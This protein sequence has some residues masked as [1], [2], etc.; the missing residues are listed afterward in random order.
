MARERVALER[1]QHPE[2]VHLGHH[3]VGQH[4]VGDSLARPLDAAGA[5]RGLYHAEPSFQ[6]RAEVRAKVRVVFHD[7]HQGPFGVRGLA[8]RHAS[9]HRRC[10]LLP[11]ASG[12]EWLGSG[13]GC[14]TS[15]RRQPAREAERE[16]GAAAHLA[17]DL[18]GAPVQ[19]HDLSHEREA[20]PRALAPPRGLGVALVE[21][22]LNPLQL[23]R[24]DARPGVLDRHHGVVARGPDADRY[25][26]PGR[27]ELDGVGENIVQR[28]LDL[29]RIQEGGDGGLWRVE[30]EVHAGTLCA[31]GERGHART[32]ERDEVYGLPRERDRVRVQTGKRKKVVDEAA[33][34]AAVEGGAVQERPGAA[35]DLE[36]PIAEVVQRADQQRQW[37]P[38]LVRDVDEESG[39]R[40]VGAAERRGPLFDDVFQV[41][42]TRFQRADPGA[43][44]A[45]PR[46]TQRQQHRHPRGDA[47]RPRFPPV[48][49]ADHG[50]LGHGPPLPAQPRLDTERVAPRRE[51]GV[52]RLPPLSRVPPLGV[53][54]D[55]LDA[56]LHGLRVVELDRGEP[57]GEVAL[58]RAET[59][60]AVSER[61][62]LAAFGA[63]HARGRRGWPPQR[64]GVEHGHARL[65]GH[66]EH[67]RGREGAR[68]LVGAVGLVVRHPV[69][70]RK[71]DGGEARG[72]PVCGRARGG[73]G[74]LVVQ[75]EH[76]AVRRDPKTASGVWEDA[77]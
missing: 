9:G 43:R 66:V 39:L 49:G 2:A 54:A 17:A 15:G 68:G 33:E 64:A 60:R 57:H 38:Q 19:L 77:V 3:E 47:E 42:L 7:E 73:L 58:A 45:P 59:Q 75:P 26:P 35:L 61:A 52:D 23:V 24:R 32:R 11:V 27:R 36:A 5:V 69:R 21:P 56:V 71:G 55:E 20:D 22:V 12:A 63:Q 48:S 76:P 30:G 31:G 28:R 8:R 37:R 50:D 51:V 70:L 34:A 13:G 40:L 29:R 10:P 1:V 46:R 67:A 65:R 18:Y 4:E 62:A 6:M 16:R 72:R 14:A 44:G 25:A 53:V 41:A 74:L